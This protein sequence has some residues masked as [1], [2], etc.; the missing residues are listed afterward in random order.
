M[1][2][3]WEITLVPPS[4]HSEMTAR[5]SSSV[6]ARD[7]AYESSD[8]STVSST[9]GA[10]PVL[11]ARSPFVGS[12]NVKELHGTTVSSGRRLGD[13]NV[14]VHTMPVRLAS[15]SSH[16]PLS[17]GPIRHPPVAVD[18]H[19]HSIHVRNGRADK[20]WLSSRGPLSH[21]SHSSSSG[22]G[23]GGGYDDSSMGSG[24]DHSS[25]SS[26]P[27]SSYGPSSSDPLL[28]S[29]AATYPSSQWGHNVQPPLEHYGVNPS[30][31]GVNLV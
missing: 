11:Q 23:G 12:L 8:S 2:G 31:N 24:V 18:Q 10:T 21:Q 1:S 30:V 6:S 20:D 4:L 25:M 7:V 29:S 14:H 19:G 27:F 16:Y 17:V 3:F 13:S 15:P 28:G 5:Q 22:G 9:R 26:S